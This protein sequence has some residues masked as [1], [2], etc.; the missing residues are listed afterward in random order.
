MD[1]TL[2]LLV[3]LA[4]LGSA[5]VGGIFYGFSSFVMRAL[6]Q[7]PPA[8]GVA[9]M[10]SINQVVITPSFML[11]FMGTALLSLV[12]VP[13]AWLW[14]PQPG[15]MLVI[16]GAAL[17]MVANFGLT[18]AVNQPMNLRL[19]ALAPADAL[20]YWADYVPTWTVWNHVRTAASLG[21]AALFTAALVTRP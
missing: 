5:I 8:Q 1:R 14:W 20:A 18:M 6:A 19:A 17:Y 4:A 9:A 10:N 16:A 11:A 13:A 3:C 2:F 15:A 12:L 21:A 7:L